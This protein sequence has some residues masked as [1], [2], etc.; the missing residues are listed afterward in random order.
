MEHLPAVSGP[1]GECKAPRC[2]NERVCRPREVEQLPRVTEPAGS[3]AGTQTHQGPPEGCPL[4][5]TAPPGLEGMLFPPP[6]A[7]GPSTG[8]PAGTW[9]STHSTVSP[10]LLHPRR[11]GGDPPWGCE[12]K[13][14]APT[15]G[16]THD[17]L[18]CSSCG[19]NTWAHTRPNGLCSNSPARGPQADALHTGG[20]AAAAS[21]GTL[22]PPRPPPRTAALMPTPTAWPCLSPPL[23]VS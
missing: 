16:I 9:C 4:E 19:K 3:C 17:Q 10:P 23:T 15:S 18:R 1:S 8:D 12:E 22:L 11:M 6:L 7:L 2:S 13:P 5:H 21:H 14:Q 20:D